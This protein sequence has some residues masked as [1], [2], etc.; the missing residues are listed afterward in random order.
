MEEKNAQKGKC[1]KVGIPDIYF[2]WEKASDN[3]IEEK[4]SYVSLRTY[5]M[6]V[7]GNCN[8]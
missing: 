8:Y 2:R 5:C 3:L 7:V 1:E 4:E 6:L